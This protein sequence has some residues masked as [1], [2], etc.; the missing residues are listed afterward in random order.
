VM[1]GNVSLDGTAHLQKASTFY[2]SYLTWQI[3]IAPV[4][5]TGFFVNKH[6]RLSKHFRTKLIHLLDQVLLS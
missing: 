2:M 5:C 3:N 4:K 1:F 6:C